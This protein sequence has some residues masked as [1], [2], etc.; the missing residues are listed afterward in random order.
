MVAHNCFFNSSFLGFNALFWT[1]DF[2]VHAMQ[3]LLQ[4]CMNAD[5][6]THMCTG[7]HTLQSEQNTQWSVYVI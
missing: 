3:K 1:P 2:C 6:Q 5:R 7:T 4:S